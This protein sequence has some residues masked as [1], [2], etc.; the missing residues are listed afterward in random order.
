LATFAVL[1][2]FD[3]YMINAF[4]KFDRPVFLLNRKSGVLP[5]AF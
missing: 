4:F 5:T 1:P 2:V 3:Q